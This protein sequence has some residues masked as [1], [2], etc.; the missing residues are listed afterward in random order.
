MRGKLRWRSLLQDLLTALPA[1]TGATLLLI[2]AI[3]HSRHPLAA[4]E[5]RT[6][7]A[8]AIPVALAGFLGALATLPILVRRL[9]QGRWRQAAASAI[10]IL[11]FLAGFIWAGAAAPGFLFST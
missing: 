3:A 1:G 8:W 2:A 10:A 6:L 5:A 4:E 7:S 9:H 11:I